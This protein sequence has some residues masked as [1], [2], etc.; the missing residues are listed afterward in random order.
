MANLV[1]RLCPILN[2]RYG[3]CREVWLLPG[4]PHPTLELRRTISTEGVVTI[5]T[6]GVVTQH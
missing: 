2:G 5:S 3:C 6:E 4:V 1:A